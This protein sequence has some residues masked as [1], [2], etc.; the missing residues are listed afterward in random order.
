MNLETTQVA[1]I[2]AG[3][4]GAIAAALLNQKGIDVIVIEKATFP[5]FSIGESLL[6]ACME[7]IRAAGMLDAVNH[8]GF[9]FKNGAAFNRRGR[10]VSFDFTDKFSQGIG[11]TFQVQRGAFDKVLAD[12]AERQGVTIRYQHEIE[13]VE[14]N[15]ESPRLTVKDANGEK[16]TLEADFILDASGFGRVLPRLLNLETPSCLPPRKAIFTHIT[17]RIDDEQYDRDKILISVHP[18]NQDVW[19]WL[20]PFSNGT[21]S[22]GIVGEPTFFERYPEDHIDAIRQLASEEPRLAILLAQAEYPNPAGEIGGYS[23]NVSTL[24][25]DKFALLGN[26]GEFLDPVFSSGVTIAMKSA[27]YA[28]DA[29]LRQLSGEKVDWTAD[30]EKPLLKGIDT[31][32]CYVEGWYK[33]TLQDV[34]FYPNPDAKIKQMICSILAGYAWDEGNPYVKEPVRRLDILASICAE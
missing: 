34:I 26:A 17:D 21:C 13:S 24:A 18:N 5:R 6:P 4:S 14:L 15:G 33:G 27:E 7:S 19:Y 23:A 3:P 25:T 29:L 2:G 8:A 12:D 9:Q 32:R 28:T 22:F 16:Y 10:Y 20:I 31:F 11:T 30:Y 1:I